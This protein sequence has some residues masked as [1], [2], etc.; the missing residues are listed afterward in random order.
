MGC[1]TQLQCG[2]VDAECPEK[3]DDMLS[4]FERRWSEFESPIITHPPFIPGS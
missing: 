2:L 3:L 1:P 4:G